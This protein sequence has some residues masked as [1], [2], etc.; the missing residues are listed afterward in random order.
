MLQ[1]LE[2]GMVGQLPARLRQKRKRGASQNRRQQ[3]GRELRPTAS[4]L[5]I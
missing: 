2:Q 4:G 5:E 3:L 1:A